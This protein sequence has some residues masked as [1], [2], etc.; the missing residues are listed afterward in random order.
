MNILFGGID[1]SLASVLQQRWSSAEPVS[2]EVTEH[3]IISLYF[4]SADPLE[5]CAKTHRQARHY[6]SKEV[7]VQLDNLSHSKSKI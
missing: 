7:L 3:V 2:S 6:L 4:S 1:I 5:L